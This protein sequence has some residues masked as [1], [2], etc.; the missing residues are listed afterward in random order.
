MSDKDIINMIKEYL[1]IRKKEKKEFGEAF[2]PKELIDEMLDKLPE[3][4]WYDPNLKWLDPANGIGNF[5]MVVYSRLME[6]LENIGG[7]KDKQKRHDHIIRNMLYMVELN[8]RNVE[9]SRRIFGEEA[10]I[11]CGDFLE[12]DILT[13]DKFDIV[14]GN[15]PFNKGIF[16]KFISTVINITNKLLFIAP[17]N[18]TINKSGKKIIQMLKDNGLYYIKFLDRNAFFKNI[19]IDTLYFLTIKDY[20]GDIIINDNKIDRKENIINQNNDIEYTIFKKILN[21]PHLEL[22]KGKN[23]TL[24]YKNTKETENIKFEKDNKH[25]HMLLSRLGGGKEEIYWINKFQNIPEHE[26]FYKM[27]FPRG[28][29]NYNSINNLKNFNKDIVYTKVVDKDTILSKSL[30]YVLL[31]KK[32]DYEYMKK[33]LMRHKLIR[34]IFIK[35]NKYSELTTELFKHIP[36]IPIDV[37]KN[38]EIYDYLKFTETEIEYIENI[39]WNKFNDI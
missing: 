24:D 38:D 5:P 23:S 21:H 15:P 1:P 29:A 9:I 31:N 32:T 14:I 4:V 13:K 39:F 2:T 28:T 35:Q 37:I 27:V 8:P 11:Y 18:F 34:F 20:N 12:D 16:T 3:E 22:F 7:L 25:P 10:N 26:D 17:S 19:D 36:K 30:L 6:S 33:Y